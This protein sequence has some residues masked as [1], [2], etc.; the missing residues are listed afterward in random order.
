MLSTGF[1]ILPALRAAALGA[2]MAVLAACATG[3]PA[4]RRTTASP[5]TSSQ[6]VRVALLVPYGSGDPGREQIARSLENA[7]RLA[8][9]DLR[10]ATI[11]LVVYPVGRHQRRRPGRRAAGGRRG[12]QDHRRPALLHRDRRRA[13]GGGRGRAERVQLLEQPLGR[14]VERLHPRHQLREHRRPA[15]RLRPRPRP[16]E[17]RRRLSGRARGRD[18]ARRGELGHLNARGATLAGLAVLQPL[19]RGHPGRRRPAAAALHRRG[20]PGDHPDRRPDRRA[21][22]HLRGACAPTASPRR[23]SSACSAGTS[24]PR[25]SAVPSLQGGVFAAP[26]PDAGRRL[27]RPLPHRLRREPARARRARLR[28]HRRGRARSSPRRAPR[29]A[30]PSRPRA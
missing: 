9:A 29:A 17:L 4:G 20:R 12:R 21:R 30:A 26:D 14:R 23:S 18:R 6:P 16:P 2:A 10:D 24:R 19:G 22:L 7:A 3:R 11:D 15:R 28:R 27:R 5:S 8:Q 13:A 1:S 25:R